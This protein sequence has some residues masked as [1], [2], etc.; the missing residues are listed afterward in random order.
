M[1]FTNKYTESFLDMFRGFKNSESLKYAIASFSHGNEPI[2]IHTIFSGLTNYVCDEIIKNNPDVTQEEI[3]IFDYI[4]KSIVKFSIFPEGSDEKDF[5]DAA[6]VSFLENLSNYA[7]WGRIE[8]SRFIPLLGEC[9]RNF[10]KDW[11]KFTGVRSPGL[12]SD[13]E[14]EEI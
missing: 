8:L 7:S 2:S 11:D 10:C 4:E 1:V 14:W 9:S 3:E 6:C 5:D 12:W 13:K